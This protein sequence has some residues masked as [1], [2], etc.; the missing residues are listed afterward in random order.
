MV[1]AARRASSALSDPPAA[2]PRRPGTGSAP[3]AAR[4]AWLP[5]LWMPA[6][7]GTWALTLV[8]PRTPRDS[9]DNDR[10]KVLIVG[11]GH[12]GL[13]CGCYLAREGLDVLVLEQSDRP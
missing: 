1:T 10:V 3:G 5:L 13:V 9:R 2:T 6:G 7:G 4:R 11:G 8:A 12:N